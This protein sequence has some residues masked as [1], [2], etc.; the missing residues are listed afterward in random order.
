M[1][2]V[3]LLKVTSALTSGAL[4]PEDARGAASVLLNDLLSGATFDG[5]ITFAKRGH[6]TGGMVGIKATL[7]A[8]ALQEAE[9]RDARRRA[10]SDLE[11]EVEP[12]LH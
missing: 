6:L 5:A 8:L 2:L 7:D 12:I 9:D 10:H 11:A 1:R 4:P 3:L